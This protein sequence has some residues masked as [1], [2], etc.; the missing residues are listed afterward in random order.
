MDDSKGGQPMHM[1]DPSERKAWRQAS[2]SGAGQAGPKVRAAMSPSAHRLGQMLL[3]ACSLGSLTGAK[4]ALAAGA[5][6]NARI[7]PMSGSSAFGVAIERGHGSVALAVLLAGGWSAPTRYD[8]AGSDKFD[9][10]VA[11]GKFDPAHKSEL[12]AGALMQLCSRL[13]SWNELAK[14]RAWCDPKMPDGD[15]IG[16]AMLSARFDLAKLGLEATGAMISAASWNQLGNKLGDGQSVIDAAAPVAGDQFAAMLAE[17][18]A[19]D[20]MGMTAAK[21]AYLVAIETGSVKMMRALLDAGVRPGPDWIIDKRQSWRQHYDKEAKSSASLLW[22]AAAS[23]AEIYAL[24]K[25]CPPIVEAAKRSAADPAI[26]A[27]VAIGRVL[28][29]AELGLA[30]DGRDAKGRGIAHVWAA[31]DRSPRDG[32]TSLA[33]K[34]PVVCDMLDASGRTGRQA[35]AEKLQGEAK[36]AFLAAFARHETREIEREMEPKKKDAPAARASR[37]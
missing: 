2:Q 29:L 33:K 34:H 27:D 17:P 6:P 31:L 26:M 7:R 37:L 9:K 19:V 1:M 20:L 24:A 5:N 3:T 12:S 22:R 8:R 15:L 36:D 25:Q 16:L 13:G 10:A 32:W 14:A 23:S 28:E 18:G 30:I 4:E 35:M 21:A 11:E